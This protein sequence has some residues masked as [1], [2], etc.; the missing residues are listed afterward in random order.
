M[1][2]LVDTSV[3]IEFFRNTGAPSTAV[4]QE[5]AET[6]SVFRTCGPVTMEVL[7]GARDDDDLATMTSILD[8]GLGIQVQPE[9]FDNAAA[10]YRS[11]QAEGITVRS[12]IDCLIAAL[13]IDEDI[14]ILHHDRDFDAIASVSPLRV[15]PASL[16]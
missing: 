2:V 9:H 14:E 6:G 5:S 1:S 16:S 7:A 15:H 3:W 11:C 10:L 12:I 13:A 4:L 8:R